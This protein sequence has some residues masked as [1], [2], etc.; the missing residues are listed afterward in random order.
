M[1]D[2]SKLSKRDAIGLAL[3]VALERGDEPAAAKFRKDLNDAANP[4]HITLRRVVIALAV[5]A[6]IVATC[7]LWLYWPRLAFGQTTGPGDKA[8]THIANDGNYTCPRN[9]AGQ[10]VMPLLP[11]TGG[12]IAAIDR[13]RSGSHGADDPT[14]GYLDE[15]G[16]KVVAW[17]LGA[18]V[19]IAGIRLIFAAI[20][21]A[22]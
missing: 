2:Y 16:L 15:S 12:V 10:C 3:V 11:E 9:E 6:V 19:V 17:I 22:K 14:A 8:L 7:V 1:K 21:K 4:R 18:V 20:R 13:E 5:L